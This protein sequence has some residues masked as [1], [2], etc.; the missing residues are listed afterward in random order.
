MK[1]NF[2]RKYHGAII[3]W[4]PPHFNFNL[5]TEQVSNDIKI[6][7][8]FFARWTT[9]FDSEKKSDF[10]YII[11]DKKLS[12]NDYSRNT[13]SKINRGL[14]KFNVKIISKTELISQGY[15]V[16]EKA[17]KRYDVVLK[18]NSEI[19]FVNEIKSLGNSWQFW[20]V[21]SKKNNILVA[22]SLNRIVDD[23]CDYSTVKLDPD[24]LRDYSSYVLYYSMN[25][26]YLNE[27]NFKYINNGT[28][29]IS[30][31]TNIH[32]FLIDKFKFRKAYCNIQVVYSPFFNTLVRYLLPVRSF[33]S[34]IPLDF[35]RKI[36]VVLHQEEIR[37]LCAKVYIKIN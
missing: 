15:C 29:S 32:D 22:F 36:Y 13:K 7:K 4:E 8:A 24:Y 12:F 18:K 27:N 34:L 6:H 14:K 33:F 30:H 35:F 19:E 11:N 28:R 5:S 21:Y 26:Y 9:D 17:L 16:Y 2:W 20:G 10:W 3:P 23:Y 37:K 1:N 31:Q 25:K